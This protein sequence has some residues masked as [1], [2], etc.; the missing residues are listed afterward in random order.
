MAT[1]YEPQIT[2][3]N[4]E[5]APKTS[6]DLTWT[7]YPRDED[8]KPREVCVR[9]EIEPLRAWYYHISPN[10]RTL[11]ILLQ[12]NFTSSD[13]PEI[14]CE[15]CYETEDTFIFAWSPVLGIGHYH[16]LRGPIR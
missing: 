8:L 14:I 10:F 12:V 16:W 9:L 7:L 1:F 11:V 4:E 6:L 15:G 13:E 2:Q 5:P 3:G